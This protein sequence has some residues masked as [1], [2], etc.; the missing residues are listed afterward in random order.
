VT[1]AENEPRLHARV[2]S[3]YVTELRDQAEQDLA[4]NLARVGRAAADRK[5]AIVLF[6]AMLALLAMNFFGSPRRAEWVGALLAALGLEDQAGAFEAWMRD[7]ESGQFHQRVFWAAARLVCYVGLPA[8]VIRAV[9]RE[10]LTDYGLSVR[11]LTRHFRPYAWCAALAAP[12]IVLASYSAGF[13]KKYPFYRLA[14]GEPLFPYFWGWELLYAAQFVALEF[15]FRG[16]LIHGLR[17]RL[18]YASILVMTMP[19]MMIHFGKPL[20][21][22]AGAII[23]GFVLGTLSYKTGSIWWGAAL[24]IAAAWGMDLLSL[25]HHG[26]L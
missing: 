25:S 8:I 18:G 21:E 5:A 4:A 13:Q 15:F 14:E 12:A 23:A 19:Y 3:T 2:W 9:L 16:F 10:R 24:H 11:G 1:S 26:H 6:T 7:D 22:A 17:G 20:P